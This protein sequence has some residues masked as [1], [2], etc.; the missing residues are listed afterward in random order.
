MFSAV[1]SEIG[2]GSLPAALVYDVTVDVPGLI[3]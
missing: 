1:Q 3:G 2:F